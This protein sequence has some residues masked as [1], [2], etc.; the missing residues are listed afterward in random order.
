MKMWMNNQ[1]KKKQSEVGVIMNCAVFEKFFNSVT[2]SRPT[3]DSKCNDYTIVIISSSRSIS[4]VLESVQ[5]NS[6]CRNVVL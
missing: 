1:K 3:F 5:A 4:V 2:Q 6:I